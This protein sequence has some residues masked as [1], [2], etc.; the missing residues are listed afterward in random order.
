MPLPFFKSYS[1]G[2]NHSLTIESSTGRRASPL[3]LHLHRFSKDHHAAV[4]TLLAAEFLPS[5]C[6]EMSA[7][8]DTF[9]LPDQGFDLRVKMFHRFMKLLP[10][11]DSL[12]LVSRSSPEKRGCVCS[13][14]RGASGLCLVDSAPMSLLSDCNLLAKTLNPRE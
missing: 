4:L 14:Y 12:A 3:F 11:Q 1:H 9:T 6:T 10:W 7:R 5:E 2:K 8:G 13:C